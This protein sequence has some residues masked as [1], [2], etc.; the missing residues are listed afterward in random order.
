ME[1][2]MAVVKGIQHRAPYST[3]EA[4]A[5][6]DY[7]DYVNCDEFIVNKKVTGKL[8]DVM[9]FFP[10]S[11]APQRGI[12]LSLPSPE[13]AVAVARALL[14]VAEGYA[15]EVRTTFEATT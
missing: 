11:S 8:V 14:T 5:Y 1:G 4:S 12:G 7:S 9:V 3:Q 10:L 2:E 6:S 15:S 13:I